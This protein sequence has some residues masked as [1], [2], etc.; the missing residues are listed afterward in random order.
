M[1][2]YPHQM[3]GG[4]RQRVVGGIAMAGGSKLIS[5]DEPTT[6]LDVTI[7]AQYLHVGRRAGTRHDDAQRRAFGYLKLKRRGAV[8]GFWYCR[9]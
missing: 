5:A 7:Q 3:S 2:E 6:N 8:G 1:R 4:M 9:T